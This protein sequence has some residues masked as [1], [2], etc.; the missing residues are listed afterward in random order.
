MKTASK[1]RHHRPGGPGSGARS[2]WG[3]QAHPEQAG[4]HLV[5]RQ[6]QRAQGDALGAQRGGADL[7][8]AQ[9]GA[10]QLAGQMVEDE[11]GRSGEKPPPRTTTCGSRVSTRAAVPTAR[12]RV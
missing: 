4:V 8:D 9:A 5:E 1:S 3:R 2:D 6:A 11:V 7:G 12:S 10:A